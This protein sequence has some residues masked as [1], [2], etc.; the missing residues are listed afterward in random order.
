MSS[1]PLALVTGAS[2]GIGLHYAERLAKDGH[3]VVLVARRKER[4]DALADRLKKEHGASC[5]VLVADLASEAGVRAIETRVAKGDLALVVNNAGVSRYKP[6]ATLEPEAIDEL[7]RLHIHGPTRITRAALPKMIEKK[8][9]A[10]VNV[11]S[12]LALSGTIPPSPMPHRAVY[13]GCKAYL[14]AFTQT[15]SHELKDKGVRVQVVLPGIVETEFHDDMGAA[16]S[17]LPPGMK[18]ENVVQ[19]SIA[20]LEK[21]EIVCIPPLEDYAVFEKIGETQRAALSS[22][23]SPKLASRYARG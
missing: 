9:G 8:S 11:A 14:L 17:H 21:N 22:A 3:D 12:L 19:A 7:V 16:K 1:R 5:E 20:A 6:F 4:L 23:L 18:P 10:I 13:A 15:L 2:S